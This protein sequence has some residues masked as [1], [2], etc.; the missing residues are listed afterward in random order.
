VMSCNWYWTGG[1]VGETS[2]P[3]QG[4]A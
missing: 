1:V 2:W 3:S 4:A